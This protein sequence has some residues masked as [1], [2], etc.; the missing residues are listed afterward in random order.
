MSSVARVHS[1]GIRRSKH[2]SVATLNSISATR[3]WRWGRCIGPRSVHRRIVKLDSPQYPIGFRL[4]KDF[5]H[6]M[7]SVRVEVIKHHI[8]H[9]NARINLIDQVPH[10][11]REIFF[12]SMAGDQRVALTR[13]RFNEEEEVAC[14]LADVVGVL[15]VWSARFYW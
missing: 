9:A 5:N 3:T 4:A 14:T 12:G 2:C 8:N 13:V 15:A 1:S 11:F 6:R 10:D 7:G